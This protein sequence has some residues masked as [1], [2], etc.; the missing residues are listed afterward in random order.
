MST[1]KTIIEIDSDLQDLIPHFVDNR[2]R[3]VISLEELIAKNDRLAIAHLAHKIKGAAAGYGFKHL[4]ALA[5]T[6]EEAN[7]RD[8]AK[9]IAGCTAE[10]KQHL[11]N[12]EI[13]YVKM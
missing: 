1:E 10:M 4:S 13:N 5:A 2:K 12:I 8:D 9:T 6:I 3:D 11:A 7:Q